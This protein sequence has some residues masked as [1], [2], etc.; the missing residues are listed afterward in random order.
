[1]T[2]HSYPRAASTASAT[3]G[4]R[5]TLWASTE[6]LHRARAHL[7]GGASALTETNDVL[8]QTFYSLRGILLLIPKNYLCIYSCSSTILVS[9]FSVEGTCAYAAKYCVRLLW[10]MVLSLCQIKRSLTLILYYS[11]IL[12]TYGSRYSCSFLIMEF[13]LNNGIIK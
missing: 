11:L 2:R 6:T 4:N 7:H 1:M 8:A 3:Y 10:P 5:G 13:I 9:L 12:T